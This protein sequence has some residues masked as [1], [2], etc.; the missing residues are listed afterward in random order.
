MEELFIIIPLLAFMAIL[1]RWMCHLDEFCGLKID[2]GQDSEYVWKDVLLFGKDPS[3]CSS[4]RSQRLDFDTV[5]CPAFP[6]LRMYR[7]VAAISEN[8]LD[9][10]LLCTLA[11]QRDPSVRTV[12]LCNGRVYR[13]IFD[14][15]A[16]DVVVTDRLTILKILTAWEVLS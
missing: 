16:V 4:L 2:P 13:E 6:L 8:D 3:L 5:E 12:A 11:K 15:P 14:Q 1:Y 10:M 9:N 7:I